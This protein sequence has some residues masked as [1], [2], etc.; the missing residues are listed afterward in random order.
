[1]LNKVVFPKETKSRFPRAFFSREE[2]EELKKI[3]PV[4]MQPCQVSLHSFDRIEF[5]GCADPTSSAVS[6]HMTLL[7]GLRRY[8]HPGV[9][10][11]SPAQA[12]PQPAR[13][14]LHLP[15]G[16][17]FAGQHDRLHR[18]A[19][20]NAAGGSKTCLLTKLYCASVHG[21]SREDLVP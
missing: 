17:L 11:N 7:D 16:P 15:N 4:G 3:G 20:C 19:R 18:P 14:Y 13:A 21:L 9:Q 8:S 1:M 10:A 6:V 12:I 5:C 2:M